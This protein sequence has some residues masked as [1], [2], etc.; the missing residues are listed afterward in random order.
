MQ[1]GTWTGCMQAC[2]AESLC[3]AA[4]YNEN[5][6]YCYLK[7]TLVDATSAS[8]Q[9]TVV[10]SAA[11]SSGSSD[12]PAA[13]C[14]PGTRNIGDTTCTISCNTDRS[15]GGTYATMQTGTFEG[16]IQAC[17]AE[18][19]CVTATYNEDTKFCYLKNTVNPSY[20]NARQDTVDCAQPTYGCTNAFTCGRNQQAADSNCGKDG[21]CYCFGFDSKKGV[22]FPNTSCNYPSCKSTQDCQAGNSCVGGCCGGICV[23]TSMAGTC[24]NSGAPSRLFVRDLNG[25][26]MDNAGLSTS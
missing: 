24:N 9:A 12:P 6:G 26:G 2:A 3:L 20:T 25:R 8:G 16:C 14:T 22:C 15:G 1:T 19:P 7:R 10:C 21:Q 11:S 5:T 17:A 18:N 4:T 23:P 13:Q